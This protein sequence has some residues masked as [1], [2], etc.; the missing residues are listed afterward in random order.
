[1][2][3]EAFLIYHLGSI[4]WKKVCNIASVTLFCP[5]VL[6]WHDT[7]IFISESNV[8]P[9]PYKVR[10]EFNFIFLEKLFRNWRK[11]GSQWLYFY[12]TVYHL[13]SDLLPFLFPPLVFWKVRWERLDVYSFRRRCYCRQP[14]RVPRLIRSQTPFVQRSV[15]PW[16]EHLVG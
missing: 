12:S 16:A 10:E 9:L 4:C 7:M 15:K 11:I 14:L 6:K 5:T 3:M 1:M 13:T 2:V 8:C